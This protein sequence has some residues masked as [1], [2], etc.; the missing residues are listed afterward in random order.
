VEEPES[1]KICT[2]LSSDFLLCARDL[3]DISGLVATP[4]QV[5]A[6]QISPVYSKAYP[7]KHGLSEQTCIGSIHGVE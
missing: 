4:L 5:M 2:S 3:L 7:K 1:L 6:S